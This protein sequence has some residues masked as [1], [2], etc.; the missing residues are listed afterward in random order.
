MNVVLCFA[1]KHAPT[2]ATNVRNFQ[3]CVLLFVAHT[4]TCV[5]RSRHKSHAAVLI[6]TPSHRA[7]NYWCSCFGKRICIAGRLEEVF[8]KKQN[9]EHDIRYMQRCLQCSLHIWH[10]RVIQRRH[11]WGLVRGW[12]KSQFRFKPF[13]INSLTP[14]KRI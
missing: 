8:G 13:I 1:T 6:R 14:Y 7:G 9:L 4:D 12:W 5:T 3:S 10:Y 11:M 2:Y